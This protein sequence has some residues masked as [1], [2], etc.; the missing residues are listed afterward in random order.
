MRQSLEFRF[1]ILTLFLFVF[2][3]MFVF[4]LD[5][6]QT[7]AQKA[8][9][10]A[11][12]EEA[13]TVEGQLKKIFAKDGQQQLNSSLRTLALKHLPDNYTDTK[14]WGLKK[15]FTKYF[16]RKR[17]VMMNHGRWRKYVVTFVEPEKNL[18]ISISELKV[19]AKKISFRA[20]VRTKFDLMAR[21]SKWVRGVQLYSVHA[22][23]TAD[24]E[25]DC[26]FEVGVQWNLFTKEKSVELSPKVTF[27]KTK[28][29]QFKIHRISNVGGEIAQ[30]LTKAAKVWLKE[31]QQKYDNKIKDQLNKSIQKKKNKWKLKWLKG[32]QPKLMT[33]FS[34]AMEGSCVFLVF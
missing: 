17:K 31:N 7:L 19:E 24:C 6:N 28:I 15:Q 23:G 33:F 34:Y 8:E 12:E 32:Q 21:Q 2:I 25:L 26:L 30:Q 10:G 22:D 4:S 11:G 13:E 3:A 5:V 29:H 14:K 9:Q 1:N 16:P 18:K 27:A 20:K